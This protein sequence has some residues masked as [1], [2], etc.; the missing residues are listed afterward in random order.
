MT[1]WDF[2]RPF[3]TRY[4]STD[5]PSSQVSRSDL[6]GTDVRSTTMFG[7]HPARRFGCLNALKTVPTA[8]SIVLLFDASQLPPRRCPFSRSPRI[9]S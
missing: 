2:E 4:T 3:D 1:T 5:V 7:S 9:R 8:A 6:L